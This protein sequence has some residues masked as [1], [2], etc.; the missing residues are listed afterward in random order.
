MQTAS[1]VV[2]QDHHATN[3]ES[4]RRWRESRKHDPAWVAAEREKTRQRVREY[5]A[6]LKAKSVDPDDA[7][8]DELADLLGLTDLEPE[9]DEPLARVRWKHWRD[10]RKKELATGET[11]FCRSALQ[12]QP[13]IGT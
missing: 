11:I 2:T 7:L 3:A 1:S 4:C 10:I 5:R 12:N 8:L 13:L 6:R 9:P